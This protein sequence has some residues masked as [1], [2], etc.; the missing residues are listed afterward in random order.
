M[1]IEVTCHCGAKFSAR[2]ELSGKQIECF[3][4]GQPLQVPAVVPPQPAPAPPPQQPASA[5]WVP[6]GGSAPSPAPRWPMF[7]SLSV[8]V[9]VLVAAG[10]LAL[11]LSRQVQKVRGDLAAKVEEDKKSVEEA[12]NRVD[13]LDQTLKQLGLQTAA[14][15]QRD[16]QLQE[17]DEE[18]RKKLETERE[19]QRRNAEELKT[20]RRKATDLR[21]EMAALERDIEAE[22]A[23]KEAGFEARVKEQ[24]RRLA[25][26]RDD[27]RNTNDL[28]QD[29]QVRVYDA[30]NQIRNLTSDIA[31][32][33][34]KVFD[35]TDLT[36][37]VSALETA[38]FAPGPRDSAERLVFGQDSNGPNKWCVVRF[39]SE[40]GAGDCY[41][42]QPG[43]PVQHKARLPSRVAPADADAG[44]FDV[45]ITF[46]YL[47][48]VYAAVQLDTQ[49]GELWYWDPT[50]NG[51]W[52]S[53]LNGRRSSTGDSQRW[54]LIVD[55]SGRPGSNP[56]ILLLDT[57]TS[58]LVTAEPT[59]YRG[60]N[61]SMTTSAGYIP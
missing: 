15:E 40:N 48:N 47:G 22:L 20:L 1:P 39:N 33:D 8:S 51:P 50:V 24:E 16:K 4:C 26:L 30:E 44:R 32:V 52:Q 54:R 5:Q 38:V 2:D 41:E 35:P 7:V 42:R 45:K 14:G 6:A 29:L 56:R 46:D 19:Q 36:N 57:R 28:A 58:E 55:D 12:K 34:A 31:A 59:Y 18:L 60:W 53:L 27:W 23:K 17:K 25:E 13:D 49:T 21:V 10:V 61:Y 37:K 11:V 3:S 9:L 43:S